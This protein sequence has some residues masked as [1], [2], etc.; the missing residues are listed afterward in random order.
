MLPPHP[1]DTVTEIAENG[2]KFQVEIPPCPTVTLAVIHHGGDL[3]EKQRKQAVRKERKIYRY[4]TESI[5][6][7]HL[8]KY[9]CIRL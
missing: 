9:S 8:V 5:V 7:T 2:L 3:K 1:F 6:F 4:R